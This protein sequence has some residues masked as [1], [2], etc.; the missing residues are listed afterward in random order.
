MNMSI[1]LDVQQEEVAYLLDQKVDSAA[2]K[3]LMQELTVIKGH[4]TGAI[5]EDDEPPQVRE[6]KKKGRKKAEPLLEAAERARA[7]AGTGE[8]GA[9]SGAE[10]GTGTGKAEDGDGREDQTESLFDF[11]G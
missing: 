10:K 7:E 9:E 6:K 11:E 4:A 2:V 1:R 8:G 3:Q 5:E